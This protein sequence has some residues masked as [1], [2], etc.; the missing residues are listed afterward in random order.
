MTGSPRYAVH[1]GIARM[2]GGAAELEAYLKSAPGM[3][4]AM[5]A[6]ARAPL[7]VIH[8]ALEELALGLGADV[9]LSPGKTIVPVYRQHVIAQIKPASRSRIDFGLALGNTPAAG[10]LLSTGGYEKKDRITHRIA[11]GSTDDIDAELR[12][13]LL[14]AYQRD[15]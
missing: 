1:P 11:V 12:R 10:R 7:R 14:T 4:D 3:V 8:D 13:W 2:G 9:R 6:G 15:G 5:Y